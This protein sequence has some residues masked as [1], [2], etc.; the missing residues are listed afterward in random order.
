MKSVEA[1]RAELDDRYG[2]IFSF[3][4]RVVVENRSHA[5]RWRDK[6]N[7]TGVVLY[8]FAKAVNLLDVTHRLCHDGFA[9]EAI[10]TSRSLFNLFINLRW[11]TKPG[12]TSQRLDRFTNYEGTSKANN[13]MTL[14][15]WDKNITKEQKRQQSAL[16]REIRPIVKELGINEGKNGMYPNWHPRIQDMAKDVDLLRDYHLTYKRLSQTEHTDPESV[17]EYLKDDDGGALM[18]GDVGPSTE[19][20][21]LVMIDS[22]RYF[23]NVKRD[24]APLLGFEENQEELEEFGRLQQKY[25]DSLANC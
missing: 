3:A 20:A 23:L 15:K 2:D 25:A 24:A 12:E 13:A 1:I 22:I 8:H 21:P 14:I 7:K 9:R 10:A 16:V 4:L 5:D 11:L 18:H 17:R 19:Y 6:E